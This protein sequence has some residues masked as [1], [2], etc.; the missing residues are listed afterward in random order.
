MPQ[1]RCEI[2]VRACSPLCLR[3]RCGIT[4]A[5]AILRFRF[6]THYQILST[7]K[8]WHVTGLA[9]VYYPP[10]ST[11]VLHSNGRWTG[12]HLFIYH[13]D[14]YGGLSQVLYHVPGYSIRKGR[15]KATRINF[16]W[17]VLECRL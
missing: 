10:P 9:P 16:T 12:D 13:H 17:K 15:C 8:V 3:P 1:S 4:S 2:G 7:S 14:P 5:E 11:S 6:F